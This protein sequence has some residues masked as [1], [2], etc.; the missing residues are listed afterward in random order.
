MA[1][2]PAET[3]PSA[4]APSAGSCRAKTKNDTSWIRTGVTRMGTAARRVRAC[5]GLYRHG[6]KYI[7]KV[8]TPLKS[9]TLKGEVARL[10]SD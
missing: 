9:L 5:A 7:R 1:R 8:K 6:N 3:D 2:I 10:Q 4:C